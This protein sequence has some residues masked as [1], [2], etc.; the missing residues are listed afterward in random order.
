MGYQ[1]LNIIVG[2]VVF[3]ASLIVYAVTIEPTASFWDCGEFI[4]CSYKLEV[5]HPPGAPFFLL[6]GRLFSLMAA[7]D[8]ESV[9][10]WV[11]MVSVVSSAFAILFLFW[12]ITHLVK[13]VLKIKNGEETLEQII[14]IIGAGAIGALSC[15]FSDS[16]WFSAVEAE[17]YGMSSFFTAFVFWA[18]LK[19][20]N[21]END[22]DGNRWLILIAYM[23]GLSIG[24][25]LLNLVTIP[26]LGLIVYFKK[27]ETITRNGI[28]LTMLAAGAII[29][30]IMIGI[31]PGLPS[32]AGSLELFFV[33]GLGLPF[34]SGV[35]FFAVAFLGGLVFGLYYTVKKQ[36]LMLN[37]ILLCF[38]FI[39]IGYS[40]YMI[41]PIRSAYNPPIDENN[42]EDILSFVSYL[43]REQYGSRP[44]FHGQYYT[45][46]ITKQV[47]GDPTYMRGKDK[48]IVKDQK[49]DYVY[50]EKQTTILPRMYSPDPNHK[51]RYQEITGLSEGEKPSFSDNIYFMVS[52]QLGKMYMRYFL[53]NFAG[54]ASDI[55]D[56]G[57]VGINGAFDELPAELAE[58]KGRNIYFAIPLL[59]G[60]LGLFIQYKKDQ[61]YFYVTLLLFFLTGAALVLYLNSPPIEPR[62][63]DYIYTGSYYVFA[64]WIG[65]GVLALFD[66]LKSVIKNGRIAAIMAVAIAS[67]VPTL[68]ASE[69]WDDH[70]RSDRYFSV[71]AAKNYLA[72]CA[73]NSI[74]FTGGDNDTFPLWYAQEV[75]GFRTDVRVIVL[76]YFNTDWYISQM[77]R[78]A[79]E[80]EALPFSLSLENYQQ[81]GLNDYLPVVERQNLKE[82]NTRTYL[83]LIKKEHPQ[84][85]VPLSNGSSYNSVPAKKMFLDVDVEKVKAMNIVPKEMEDNIVEKM[86][87]SIKGRGL[88]KNDLGV[89]DLI[90][91]SNWERPIYF[92]TTSLSSLN[93]NLRRYVVQE[94]IAYRLTP[95]RNPDAQNMMINNEVMYDNL[96]NKYQ[97][98]ELDNPD[99]YYSEDYRNF[100]LNHRSA[101]NTLAIS[102]MEAG[103]YDKAKNVMEKSLSVMPDKAIPYDYFNVQ[104]VGIMLQLNNLDTTI[105]GR[106][107]LQAASM[108]SLADDIASITLQRNTDMLDYMIETGSR[109]I[110]EIQKR[111]L[112][113]NELARAYRSAGEN[114]KAAE[115]EKV[116]S[117]YYQK[118][119]SSF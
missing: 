28:I 100:C 77:M 16:F 8:V 1:K 91:N 72:T 13:R 2:W 86:T 67:V 103:D 64:I 48:Y 18:I 20:E 96:M 105:M 43:K 5:P 21:I 99:V 37:T 109:D 68:M 15:T 87:W 118:L 34:G 55:Q 79:Y 58:N 90:A 7:G 84:L 23:M 88:E 110:N 53:W 116:F 76:S 49:V 81:G 66:I 94:G 89:I 85:Q 10:Y 92:N 73:P 30:L 22:S 60:I 117:T 93:I 3:F 11:T 74:I 25:H 82:I 54:R 33:N 97:W 75:E 27:N 31:I 78:N 59:L 111:V 36:K 14:M 29:I 39:I 47:A 35:I 6:I 70:D 9:A 112:S 107:N 17:V 57:W 114:E 80:S 56:A 40:S 101:F 44:L 115:Y 45:A 95:V 42:P 98:R 24:V 50:D 108:R 38:T 63:R 46:E 119:Q 104:Q 69:N 32:L 41:V 113:L 19:W 61:K 26:A 106:D 62:E 71:D 83:Q 102:L 12:S 4:A 51:R 52:H 65:F